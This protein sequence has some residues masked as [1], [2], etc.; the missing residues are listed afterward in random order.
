M[1]GAMKSPDGRFLLVCVLATLV[2]PALLLA[3]PFG[4]ERALLGVLA[5]WALVLGMM[6]P[7][8]LLLSRALRQADASAFLK[9]SLGGAL[10]RMVVAVAGVLAFHRLAEPAPLRSF[11]A[12]LFVGY[13]VLTAVELVAAQRALGRGRAARGV[14]GEL[15]P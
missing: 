12:S 13:V 14:A 3:L 6:L 11:L 1:S 4:E 7:S 15:R 9:A 2:L 8:H 10:L 5:G